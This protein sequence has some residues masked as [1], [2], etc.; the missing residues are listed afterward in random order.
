MIRCASPGSGTALR[1]ASAKSKVA[2]ENDPERVLALPKHA[3]LI[4]GAP[5]ERA[6]EDAL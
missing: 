5:A 6:T 4:D 2:G 1:I 3:I